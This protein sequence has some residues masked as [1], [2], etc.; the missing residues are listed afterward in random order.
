MGRLYTIKHRQ[1]Y[2]NTGD[3]YRSN[4]SIVNKDTL[5][6]VAG[7]YGLKVPKSHTKER[8]AGTI[9]DFVL[10]NPETCLEKLS[11]KELD[12]L[13]DFVK[14]GADTHVVRPVRKFYKTMRELLLVSVCHNKKERKLYFLLPDELR[15]LFAPLLDK[16]IKDARKREKDIK[17]A[18]PKPLKDDVEDPEYLD[19]DD[20]TYYLDDDDDDDPIEMPDFECFMGAGMDDFFDSVL[21]VQKF[22]EHANVVAHDGAVLTLYASVVYTDLKTGKILYRSEEPVEVRIDTEDFNCVTI[23]ALPGTFISTFSTHEAEMDYLYG[24]LYIKGSDGD[25]PYIVALL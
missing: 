6:H 13:K 3:S 25:K 7:M 10:S 18:T 8:M 23:P 19:D 15:E 24:V 1:G 14:A 21:A 22:H 17:A 20:F 4:L 5:L 12:V 2:T 11:V 9:A 16:A